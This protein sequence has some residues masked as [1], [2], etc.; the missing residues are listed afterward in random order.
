MGSFTD[1]ASKLYRLCL[2]LVGNVGVID[3]CRGIV[4]GLIGG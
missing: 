4:R 1:Q 3:V 2:K